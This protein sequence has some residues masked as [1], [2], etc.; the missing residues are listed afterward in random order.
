MEADFYMK[1]G[2]LMPILYATLTDAAGVAV[3]LT[4]A[5]S[6]H[7]HMS[8]GVDGDAKVETAATGRVS[9]SWSDGDTDDDGDFEAE[10]VVLWGE[11]DTLPQHFPSDGY[12]RIKIMPEV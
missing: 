3:D 6:V 11:N 9:Y 5:K 7:F 10:F 1:Q 2:D 4:N 12:I 8:N